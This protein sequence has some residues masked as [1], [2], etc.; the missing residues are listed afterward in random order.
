MSDIPGS[1][2]SRITG[3]S[4]KPKN[5][6][7]GKVQMLPQQL[8]IIG[9]GNDD[10]L[11]SLDKYECESSADAVGAKYGYGSPLHLAARQLFPTIGKTATFPVYICPVK[12]GQSG[13]VKATG[14]VNVD[15]ET[16]TAN[17]N[18]ILSIAG[19]DVQ[20][21]VTKGDTPADFMAAMVE[22]INGTL[23]MPVTAEVIPAQ[24]EDPAYVKL[25]ARWSGALSNRISLEFSGNVPGFTVV[26]TAFADGAG[27]PDVEGALEAI[28]PNIWATFILNTFDYKNADGSESVV[29]DKYFAFGEGRWSWLE[30]MPCYV[31]HGCVDDYATR[32]AISD[33]RKDDYINFYAISVGSPELPFAVAARELLELLTTANSNPAQ[34]YTGN[35]TG[36]KRG[37]DKLQESPTV[38]NNA[39]KKGSSTNITSGSVAAI[40]DV[41]SFYH[42]TGEGNFPARRYIV[43]GVKLMN[44]V[45]NLRIIT[46]DPSVKASPLIPENQPTSNP[47]AKSTKDFKTWFAN[48]AKSLGD[49][50]LISDVEFTIKNM[51]VSIDSANS[52][53]VNYTFPVKVSGNIEVVD[54]DV[55]FG[56]YVGE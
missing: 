11:Y 52:K 55:L 5:F 33:N 48:L 4:V 16:A 25:T 38:R 24:N 20:L 3:I 36:L 50:A 1:W 32:T 42:P 31:I 14:S 47:T 17:G 54:G 2:V 10:V 12:I 39:V 41:V 23:G 15:G 26:A 51:K 9:Q 21:A 49:N 28:G 13:F 35:L 56:Q 53:R 45:Y 27:V 19:F 40:N 22:A 44:I 34:G 46:E 29:L 30:K 37:S 18:C 6:N 8:V 7:T 43:D